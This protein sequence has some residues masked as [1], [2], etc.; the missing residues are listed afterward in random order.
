MAEDFMRTVLEGL[1]EGPE[2]NAR[3]W[4][5]D[6]GDCVVFHS[7]DKE[8]YAD[9]VDDLLTLYRSVETD[10]VTGFQ[11]KGVAAI[12]KLIGCDGMAVRATT[13][14][15]AVREVEIS[16][17]LVVAACE[18]DQPPDKEQRRRKARAYA[19]AARIAGAEKVQVGRQAA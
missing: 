8:G 16:A 10:Q 13:E 18:A 4:Y 11:V 5:N 17:L 6:Y 19:E 15:G 7:T 1:E 3:P 12:V 14:D 2:F 9:R